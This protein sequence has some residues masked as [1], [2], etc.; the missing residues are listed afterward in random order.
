MQA[1]LLTPAQACNTRALQNAT[2]WFSAAGAGAAVLAMLLKGR[3]RVHLVSA[4]NDDLLVV[5][6][7]SAIAFLFFAVV[8]ANA[9][10]VLLRRAGGEE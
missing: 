1:Q 5:S 3:A 6:V 4:P 10:L 9:A 2:L 7:M 8:D